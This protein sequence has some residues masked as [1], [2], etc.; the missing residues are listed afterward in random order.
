MQV[1]KGD[2]YLI[3]LKFSLFLLFHFV[4]F[5]GSFFLSNAIWAAQRHQQLIWNTYVYESAYVRSPLK[6][7]K[8]IQVCHV[9]LGVEMASNS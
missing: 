6:A 8:Y 1:W 3:A 5:S 7:A 9:C 2:E 4:L